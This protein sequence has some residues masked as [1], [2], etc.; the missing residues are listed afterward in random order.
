MTCVF[1]CIDSTLY[2]VNKVFEGKKCGG[3]VVLGRCDSCVSVH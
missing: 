2:T 1:Q 3:V